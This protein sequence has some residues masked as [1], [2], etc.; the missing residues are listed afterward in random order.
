MASP[1]RPAPSAS[2]SGSSPI[3][4]ALGPTNTG[5]T[6]QAVERMLDHRS[7]MIGLPLRLLARE[8]YDR[9]TARIGERAVA[10]V[11]GEERRV[12]PR[13]RYWV[14]T[15]EAM[16]VGR[17]V[18]FVA[19]DEIQLAEHA[20]RGH[21]FTDRIL[22]ARGVRE[23]WLMGSDTMRDRLVELVP[24]AE[25]QR[26][27]RLSRLSSAG[28]VS[29]KSL[30]PRS[31]VV[32]FSATQVY[33][34]AERIQRKRG[35]TAVVLGALSPR[36]RNAQVAMYQA[37]E[38]QYM[39]AT[40]AIGM[41]LNMNVDLVA[42]AALRK[43][44]GQRERMLEPAELAQIAG[45]AGRHMNDG[46]FATLSPLPALPPPV[47]FAL[48]NHVFPPVR[49]LWWRNSDLDMSSLDALQ[50]SLRRRPR[51]ANLRLV[52]RAEDDTAL[53][54]LAKR[55]E[56]R[57][58]T[59]GAER[60]ATLWSVCQIP[61]FRQLLIDSHLRLLE[62]IFLQLTGPAGVI[63]TDWMARRIARLDDPQGDIE[64][65]MT[66]ISFIRTWTYVANHEA[67]VRDAP[68]W[69]ERTREIEDRLSDALHER[70]VQRFVT[71]GRQQVGW[72]AK[73]RTRRSVAASEGESR[74]K[75]DGPFSVLAGLKVRGSRAP[76]EPN[77]Q[78]VDAWVDSVAEADHDAFEVD[79]SGRIVFRGETVGRLSKGAELLRPEAVLAAGDDLGAGARL[80]LQ[81]R[82]SAL[83][84][85]W[86]D[87]TL[88]PVRRPAF[89]ALSPAG[90]GLVYQLEQRLGTVRRD[91]AREQ[92]SRLTRED[93]ETLKQGG[94][95]LGTHSVFV[96]AMT[97]P[98]AIRRRVVLCVAYLSIRKLLTFP[99]GEMTWCAVDPGVDVSVYTAMGYPVV[100]DRGVRADVV[101]RVVGALGRASAT[102][103]FR[104]PDTVGALLGLR[105]GERTGAQPGADAEE[106]M[107]A[108]GYR[109][110]RSGPGERWE[111]AVRRRGR[112]GKAAR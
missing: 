93:R 15:T 23:T 83:A 73:S 89:D 102:G 109:R 39:V 44:D 33:E 112:K 43:F 96:R 8:V 3:I 105:W 37:G 69:Q 104:L 53:A 48:E 47:V 32:A 95:V 56:V 31:A 60:V 72:R 88:A 27:P 45:R 65:L 70:L 84:R 28:R 59:R 111:R 41:G 19:I 5:K 40:D 64:T 86:V 4:A 79:D 106:M 52:D 77:L 51:R 42:F 99:D 98:K 110:A 80:R 26:R 18:D 100:G 57:R 22:H 24:T 29:L 71:Q 81:R 87:E 7:G 46:A 30:P 61:D 91:Q 67:W 49:R 76:E 13:P 16:P 21:V 108:L 38:V 25:V 101:E 90:R 55:P 66:R 2:P 17:D 35:G 1:V 97:E 107:R 14:C 12:P 92:I 75:A 10:L 58:R 68:F 9:I 11:T 103:P 34:L 74:P 62:E 20:Q 63:D 54:E 94:V 85:D 6:H 50:A 36:T 78:T 82:L